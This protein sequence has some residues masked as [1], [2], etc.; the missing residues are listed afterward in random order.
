M[1]E[2]YESVKTAFG[3]DIKEYLLKNPTASTFMDAISY[4]YYHPDYWLTKGRHEFS[5]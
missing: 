1:D 4:A 2:K 5:E 3:I